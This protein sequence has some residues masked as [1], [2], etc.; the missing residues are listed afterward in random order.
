M[1]HVGL[2]R[3]SL[4]A[5]Q[6]MDALWSGPVLRVARQALQLSRSHNTVGKSKIVNAV[7]WS[8]TCLWSEEL[9]DELRGSWS[10]S[11]KGRKIWQAMLI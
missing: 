1:L 7:C 8:T 5:G 9:V 4:L 10:W 11:L 2:A 3:L 6:L